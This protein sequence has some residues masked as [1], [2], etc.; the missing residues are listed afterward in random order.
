MLE[1]PGLKAPPTKKTPPQ[2]VRETITQIA[3]KR[4]SEG[5]MVR[6]P[7]NVGKSV[8]L[9]SGRSL[10]SEVRGLKADVRSPLPDFLPQFLASGSC[11]RGE[12]QNVRLRIFLRQS[13]KR[14]SQ[15]VAGKPVA[16]GGDDQRR[17]SDSARKSSNCRSAG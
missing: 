14:V 16:L 10:R 15:L 1:V 6:L 17:A 2:P 12:R 7:V 9:Y 11:S 5:F 8:H 4:E 13:L 3:S